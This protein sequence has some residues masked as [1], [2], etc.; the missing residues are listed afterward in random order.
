[1]LGAVPWFTDPSVSAALVAM[2]GCIVVDKRYAHYQAVQHLAAMGAGVDQMLLGLET[3]GPRDSSGNPP[4]IGPT[5]PMPGARQLEPV[6][7]LGYSQNG[8]PLMHIKLAVCCGAWRWEG[9]FGEELE[10]L[11]PLGVWI[12]SANWTQNAA[13]HIEFGAWTTDEALCKS[14]LEFMTAVIKASEPLTSAAPAPLPEL[15][16]AT[17]DDE[18][19]TDYL[20][21]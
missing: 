5:G 14:A 21:E 15:S 7:L 2:A 17:W 6:R 11:T 9:E 3:W 1:V 18:A 20:G 13:Q 10:N 8:G 12:G 16:Q 4:I 19:M